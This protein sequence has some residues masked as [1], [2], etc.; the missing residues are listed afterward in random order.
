VRALDESR[1]R[2]RAVAVRGGRIVALGST[3]AILPFRAPATRWIDCAGATLLPGLID[4]HLHLHALAAATAHLDCRRF[5]HVGALLDGIAVYAARQPRGGWIR[6]DGLDERR[7]GR[8]PTPSELDR[9]APGYCVRLRHRSLHGSLL[10]GRALARLRGEGVRGANAGLVVGQEERLR[11]LVGPL[12]AATLRAGFQLV[13]RRL[14]RA[15]LTTIADATPRT[16]ASLRALADAVAAG[17]FPLRVLVMRPPGMPPWRG[18][19]RL[20]P[21]PVK[22]VLHEEGTG[23]RPSPRVLARQIAAAAA[24]GDAVAVHCLGAHALVAALDAFAR[25]PAAARRGRGHRLEHVAE[26]PPALIAEIKRL[27]LSVVTNPSFVWDRG[28]V[29]RRETPPDAHAWVYRARSLLAAGV[30]LAAASDA[31]VVPADPWRMM[32]AARL[33]RTRRGHVLGA[34]ERLNATAALALCTRGAAAA[35]DRPRLGRLRVGGPADLI[36]VDRDPIC[37][38][39]AALPATQVRLTM[40][41]GEVVWAR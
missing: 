14:V 12:P 36:V 31:P 32:A 7:L 35:L 5:D 39:V 30:P 10:S 15:G 4:P 8:W 28:D 18:S 21:G 6:G 26:C 37:T 25:L 34:Q 33:R 3:R 13:G 2:P 41:A 16:R 11:R 20:E 38:A 29:Y 40:I 22:I 9:A 24:A 17:D 27:G 23:L 1:G 19:G